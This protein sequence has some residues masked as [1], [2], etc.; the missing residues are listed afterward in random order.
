[1][2]R[3]LRILHDLDGGHTPETTRGRCVSKAARHARTLQSF[4]HPFVKEIVRQNGEI[5]APCMLLRFSDECQQH[6]RNYLL[7]YFI[8]PQTTLLLNSLTNLFI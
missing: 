7:K 1:M 4:N 3:L 8:K 2:E 5:L 6:Y